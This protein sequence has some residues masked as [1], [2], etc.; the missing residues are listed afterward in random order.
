[1]HPHAHTN[2]V[3][4]HPRMLRMPVRG[5]ASSLDQ[6]T[7]RTVNDLFGLILRYDK[8]TSSQVLLWYAHFTHAFPIFNCM[9]YAQ[10]IPYCTVCIKPIGHHTS[11]HIHSPMD[12]ST[13]CLHGWPI[14][15]LRHCPEFSENERIP[16]HA[17]I[18]ARACTC[19]RA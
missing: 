8:T 9:V 15:F 5:T 12:L 17:G 18:D 7:E 2:T 13:L 14:V 19:I 6:L 1:M 10:R 11:I 3:T 16:G 4:W